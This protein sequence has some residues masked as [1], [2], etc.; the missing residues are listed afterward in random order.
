MVFAVTVPFKTVTSFTWNLPEPFGMHLIY[1]ILKLY[2][3]GTQG[4]CQAFHAFKAPKYWIY[5]MEQDNNQ[6]LLLPKFR[7]KANNNTAFR[8]L[9]YENLV[10]RYI[11]PVQKFTFFKY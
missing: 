9:K 3:P 4:A 8:L 7:T 1:N 5:T 6:F 2:G 10:R 11:L